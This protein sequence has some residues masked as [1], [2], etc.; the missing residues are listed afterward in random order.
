MQETTDAEILALQVAKSMLEADRVS[1]ALDIK[2]ESVSPGYAR[3][4][5]LVRDDMVNGLGIC[6]GGIT[7]S[8]ADTSFALAC[9]SRNRK[10]VALSCDIN[11]VSAVR[12]GDMLTARAEERSLSGRTGVYD[13]TVINQKQEVVAYFRGTA[14]GTSS[15]VIPGL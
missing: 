4:S 7:F 3:T 14:Y 5:M 15:Q 1:S 6:H 8:L 9:N 11:Y 10:T 12:V 2:L 13:V